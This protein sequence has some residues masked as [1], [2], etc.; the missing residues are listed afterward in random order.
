[1]ELRKQTAHRHLT[2]LFGTYL[3]PVKLST[4]EQT[5]HCN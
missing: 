1:M 2:T 3:V 4:L 5:Q